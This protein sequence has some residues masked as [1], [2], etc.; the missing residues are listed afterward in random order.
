MSPFPP[1]GGEG[2][3]GREGE[4]ANSAFFLWVFLSPPL[5]LPRTGEGDRLLAQ[6]FTA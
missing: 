6:G 1:G 3:Q 4:R 2:E 5:P